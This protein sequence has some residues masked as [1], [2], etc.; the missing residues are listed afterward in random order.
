MSLTAKAIDRRTLTGFVAVILVLA[1]LAAYTK[2][3]QLEDPEFTIKNAVVA[4]TYPGASPEEVELEVTDVIERAIQE[5]PEVKELESTTGAGISSIKVTVEA[6]YPSAELPQIWDVLRKKVRDAESELPPGAGTPVVFD[7][8]ADVYGFLFAVYTDSFTW[9]ELER[10][11][12]GIKKELAV[13]PG[14]AKVELWGVR[15]QAIYLDVSPARIS[16]LGLLRADVEAALREQNLVIDAGA[17][18]IGSQRL[19]FEL[20]GEFSSVEEIGDVVI[21]GRSLS[22]GDTGRLV[23]VRDIA[24]VRRGYIEPASTIMRSNGYPAIGMAVSNKSGVNI[25]KLGQAIDK[26]LA[27]LKAGLPVGVEFEK[28]SWQSE[29]VSSAISSFLISLAQA[30]GI[31]IFVLWIAMGLRSSLIVGITGLVM[32]IIVTFLVM[33]LIGEDL[34]RMSL[35]A[36]IIAMGMMVDNAIVVT[37]GV[38]VRMQR[39][40]DRIKAASE[41]ATQPSMPLLGATIVAVMAFFP[42]A[43]STEN[44]GEYCAALF[45][46]AGVSLMISWLLAVTVAPLVCVAALPKPKADAGDP[47][48]GWFY[49]LFRGG[50]RAALKLRWLVL[51]ISIGI[52]VASLWSFRF[53]DNMFFPASA[54]AQFMVDLW[55]PQGTRIDITSSEIARLEER[56]D[57]MEAVTS[58]N[59]FIGKGPPRFYLPVEPEAQYSSYGQLIVNVDD[60]K[61]VDGLLAD[62]QGWAD[63]NMEGATVITRKYGLGPYKSWPVDVKISGPALA[64]PDVLRRLSEEAKAILR[65]SPHSLAVRTNWRD[66]TPKVVAEYDQNNARWTGIGRTDIAAALRR[67]YDGRV[68]GLYRERDK[69]IPIVAR[70]VESTREELARDLDLVPV[71]PAIGDQTVPLSQATRDIGVQWEDPL[72]CRFDRRR[73]IAAQAVPVGLATDLL[74]DVRPKIDAI[75]LPPGYDLMWDGEYRSTVD[76]QASLVPGIIPALLIMAIIVVALFNALR[77]PLVILCIVPFAL[78]GV[79][80]GLLATGQP[81]GFVA[82]LGAMSLAGMMIKNAIVLLDEINLEKAAGRSEYDAIMNAACSR[83]RPVLLAAGTTVLGVIP[84]LPD[85]F[86]ASMAIVIMF[87]LSIGSVITMILLPVVYSI[88]F[89]VPTPAESAA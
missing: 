45:T 32:V 62:I 15:P 69:L 76:S 9:A 3:G 6:S 63:E 81:F 86:W 38:I 51:L 31:V 55:L 82:L 40:M 39:G 52:L 24:E 68:I 66:R 29:Q 58:I 54:R 17:M 36:L 88:F 4:T 2:L 41:A 48:G 12:D 53:V 83:L 89:R 80:V 42:I 19:R 10:R 25:V 65:E 73:A 34:H 18:E 84:L 35:G 74:A 70:N 13:V 7:E 72:I 23:R 8:F 33:A 46:I 71:R 20:T 16:Q 75:E 27:E 44:A 60:P 56:I 43:A 28:I 78:V 5:M 85:V 59:T 64:D 57:G 30:V 1:G 14:V 50:L 21:R 61:V 11:V 79:V 47:F 87:G 67:S 26:R 22:E 37:D 77:P 49:R